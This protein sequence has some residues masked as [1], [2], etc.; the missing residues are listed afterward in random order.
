[1]RKYK[2]K[3][4]TQRITATLLIPLSFWLIYNCLLFASMNYNQ[5][6]IFFSSTVNSTL[7]T[8]TM[9]TILIHAK[10]G[11]ETIIEDYIKP[12][13]FKK[14]FKLLIN[15]LVYASIFVVVISIT[16]ILLL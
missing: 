5:L 7:F 14:N 2:I 6:I 3:W 13:N 1:M 10:I 16:K 12:S 8:I 4:L 11:F 9:V 15:I